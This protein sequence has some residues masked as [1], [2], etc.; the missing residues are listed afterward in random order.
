YDFFNIINNKISGIFQSNEHSNILN[1]EERLLLLRLIS[2]G[3]ILPLI[4]FEC[5][6]TNNTKTNIESY[7]PFLIRAL[8]I[9]FETAARAMDVSIAHPEKSIGQIEE[10]DEF[11]TFFGQAIKDMYIAHAVIW[12]SK[13][14]NPDTTLG[15]N[16]DSIFGIVPSL[17]KV[18]L[19]YHGQAQLLGLRRKIC[20]DD[21]SSENKIVADLITEKYLMLRSRIETFADSKRA[22]NRSRLDKVDEDIQI[23]IKFINIGQQVFDFI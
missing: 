18:F 23:A 14:K 5:A 22:A 12:A 10:V 3:G 20:L 2:L 21:F 19:A 17:L 4:I 15:L 6:L 11:R 8:N 7:P 1:R 9:I 13:G 16:Q